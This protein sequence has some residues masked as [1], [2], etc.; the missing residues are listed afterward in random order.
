MLGLPPLAAG[1]H[2]QL[3]NVENRCN[4]LTLDYYYKCADMNMLQA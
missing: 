4:L 2:T 3:L 1:L